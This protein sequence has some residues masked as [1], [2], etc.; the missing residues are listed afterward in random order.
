MEKTREVFLSAKTRDVEF[1]KKQL[2]ALMR[3]YEENEEAFCSALAKD[4]RKVTF[5]S[6][7]YVT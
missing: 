1:R 4:L 6:N 3:M 7:K 5:I 2:K